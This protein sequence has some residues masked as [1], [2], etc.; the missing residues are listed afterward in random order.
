M[1]TTDWRIDQH[2]L[3]I[4][5]RYHAT[6]NLIVLRTITIVIIRVAVRTTVTITV[7]VEKVVRVS[8]TATIRVVSV[9]SVVGRIAMV[10]VGILTTRTLVS[11]I[12]LP[13]TVVRRVV[14]GMIAHRTGCAAA[15]GRLIICSG[16]ISTPVKVTTRTADIAFRAAGRVTTRTAVIA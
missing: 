14:E 4:E 1:S 7:V 10:V 15:V 12:S 13:T 6:T 8:I 2:G 11:V 3:E 5:I 16:L 9:P